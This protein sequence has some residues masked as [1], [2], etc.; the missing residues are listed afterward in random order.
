MM[1]RDAAR[2]GMMRNVEEIFVEKS[3][4]YIPL[5]RFTYRLKNNTNNDFAEIE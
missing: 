2:I 3:R 5:E 1:G 4:R